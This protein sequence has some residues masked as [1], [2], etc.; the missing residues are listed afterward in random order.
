MYQLAH[1][2]QRRCAR[3]GQPLTDAASMEEGLGPICRNLDNAVLAK[4]IPCNIAKARE[5]FSYINAGDVPASR[6]QVVV[7]LEAALIE[8]RAETRQ[9]WRKEVKRIEWLL[10]FNVFPGIRLK[11]SSLVEALGYVGLA[12]LWQGDASTGPAQVF[13]DMENSLLYLV[14]SDVKAGRLAFKKLGS[15][16]K[17][18]AI[19]PAVIKAKLGEQ[20][21]K[22]S[23]WALPAAKHEA[24]KEIVTKHWVNVDSDLLDIACEMAKAV[25]V[26]ATPPTP[27]VPEKKKESNISVTHEDKWLRIKTP[28]NAAYVSD[29]KKL[30]PGT[31]KWS[32]DDYC[33]RVLDT[34]KDKVLA[35]IQEHYGV[36]V[37]IS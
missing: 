10:S 20:L 1:H 5:L 23:F 9:D 17:S 13:F 12:A 28:Y 21:A 18:A 26:P 8:E 22:K 37:Q 36:S 31:R 16:Q 29:I 2:S 3:C 6:L 7:D 25:P 11:F 34:H 35:L 24:F 33:W 4:K 14:G 27:E 32:Y 15:Y 19:L 30:P